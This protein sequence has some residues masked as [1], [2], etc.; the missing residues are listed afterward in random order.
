MHGFITAY[1]IHYY[2]QQNRALQSSPHS[3]QHIQTHLSRIQ[4]HGEGI[5]MDISR[6]NELFDKPR[7][8][9]EQ[10]QQF[11]P[12]TLSPLD[13]DWIQEAFQYTESRGQEPSPGQA[14][15]PEAWQEF[16][17]RLKAKEQGNVICQN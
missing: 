9:E 6:V 5:K 8:R 15:T 2:L 14:P 11:K 3:H 4:P 12:T 7:Q 13:E 16:Q 10:E 1:P 17:L